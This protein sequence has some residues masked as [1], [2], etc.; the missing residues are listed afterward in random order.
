MGLDS[1]HL[2]KISSPC[3]IDIGAEKPEEIALSIMAEV[4]MLETGG[5][6]RRLQ[7]VKKVETEEILREATGERV[8]PVC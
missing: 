2:S 8:G 5:T 6:A 4:L 3:G 1:K 7:E